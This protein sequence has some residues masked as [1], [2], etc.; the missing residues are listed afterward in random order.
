M[1][2]TYFCFVFFFFASL[3][4][5]HFQI[6]VD[7]RISAFVGIFEELQ[8]QNKRDRDGALAAVA[9]YLLDQGRKVPDPRCLEIIKQT[10]NAEG[11]PL[12]RFG[13]QTLRNVVSH[14]GLTYRDGWVYIN[15]HGDADKRG[16]FEAKG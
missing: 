8:R 9:G 13:L 5:N 4:E 1:R 12:V 15:N 11:E 6:L 16:V 3:I 10:K 7:D 14:E 2:K